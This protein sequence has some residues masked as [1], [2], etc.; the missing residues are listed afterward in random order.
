M[1]PWPVAP[2]NWNVHGQFTLI[3]QGY[4]GFRSPYQGQNSLSGAAQLKNT[5]SA[6]AFLGVRLWDGMEFYVNLN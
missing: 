2:E 6:T 3:G 1:S 5:T 4:P